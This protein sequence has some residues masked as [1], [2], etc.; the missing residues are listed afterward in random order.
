MKAHFKIFNRMHSLARFMMPVRSGCLFASEHE[1][2]WM[3]ALDV[4]IYNLILMIGQDGRM[5]DR[6]FMIL[7][8]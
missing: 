1:E 3:M 4:V 6:T 5:G 8:G 2:L 7:N